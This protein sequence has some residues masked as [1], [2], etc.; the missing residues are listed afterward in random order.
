MAAA[1]KSPES[2]VTRQVGGRKRQ[3]VGCP[4]INPLVW[5]GAANALLLPNPDTRGGHMQLWEIWQ[6]TNTGAEIHA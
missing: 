1:W 4:A 3:G 2:A 5:P 6:T